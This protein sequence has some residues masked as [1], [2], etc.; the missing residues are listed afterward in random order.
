MHAA[1]LNPET[2]HNLTFDY[3]SGQW[4]W[5]FKYFRPGPRL[6]GWLAASLHSRLRAPLDTVREAG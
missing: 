2:F 5:A 1:E 4:S 6:P 3:I